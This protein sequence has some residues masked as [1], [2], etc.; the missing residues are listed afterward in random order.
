MKKFTLILMSAIIMLAPS[1]KKQPDRTWSKH[2]VT[3]E[4]VFTEQPKPAPE[5]PKKEKE[6]KKAKTPKVK[7][8]K[9]PK[10]CRLYAKQMVKNLLKDKKKINTPIVE[11]IKV[12]YYECNNVTARENLYKLQANGLVDVTYSEIKNKYNKPTYWVEVAL[13][14]DGEKLIV[15]KD[16]FYPEDSIDIN[17]MKGHVSP[18]SGK[19][20]Y[21]EYTFDPNVDSVIIDLIHNFYKAYVVNQK[22]AIKKYAT[23]DLV[24][25]YDRIATAKELGLNYMSVDPFVRNAAIDKNALEVVV[26]Q[27]TSY[28]DLYRVTLGGQE[29]CIVV[30]DMNGT[31]KIDDVALHNPKH[32]AQKR[33][34][35]CTALNISAQKL[36][37]A[38][39][40]KEARPAPKAKKA[41]E[42]PELLFDEYEPT[43]QPGIEQ[44]EHTEP[45]PYQIAKQC[46]HF[47]VYNLFAGTKKLAK[48]GKIK[49]VKLDDLMLLG[50][51][52]KEK[53]PVVKKANVTIETV[54][55]SPVGRI[56]KKLENGET[57]KYEVHFIYE[58]DEWRCEI[59]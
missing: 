7:K 46:E 56:Y 54:K 58:E 40:K 9:Q 14:K 4:F 48:M 18:E 3:E 25:A 22:S 11:A 36:H 51:D 38:L 50:L 6:P 49:D 29:F 15:E 41:V 45:L 53:A 28:V 39:K 37:N 24:Q 8:E 1:C 42:K 19:N 52:D 35:R 57:A 20:K 34:M 12:G 13:T 5:T 59:Q 27:W 23:P 33:T 2:V 17:Y 31:K 21:G 47:K 30:K 32:L 10:L 55:V 44:A 43:L 16:P 26:H